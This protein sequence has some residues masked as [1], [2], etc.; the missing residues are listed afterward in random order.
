MRGEPFL[1]SLTMSLE[2]AEIITEIPKSSF[3]IF[4]NLYKELFVYLPEDSS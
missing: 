1:K 3:N 4:I 2:K